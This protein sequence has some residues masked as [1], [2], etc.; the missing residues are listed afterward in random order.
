VFEQLQRNS[1][2]RV[3]KK[4]WPKITGINVGLLLDGDCNT[5]LYER[6]QFVYYTAKLLPQLQWP[7]GKRLGEIS[8]VVKTPGKIK[9]HFGDNVLTS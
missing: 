5:Y 3:H 8:G 6:I 7:I 1:I 9:I 2:L 4:Y